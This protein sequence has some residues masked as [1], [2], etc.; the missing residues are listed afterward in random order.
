[1]ERPLCPAG[2][3][4]HEERG[5]AVV[6]IHGGART[7][8]KAQLTEHE[9]LKAAGTICP[10]VFQRDGERIRYVPQA[11]RTACKAAG[12]PGRLIHDMRRSA[13]RTFER[14]GVPRSVAMSIVGHKTESIYRR[15]AIV[16]EQCNGKLLLG[17]TPAWYADVASEEA[18]SRPL[19]RKRA[20]ATKSRS[21]RSG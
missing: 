8:L 10:F 19:G 1:M 11:W 3:T 15:Y 6:P 9:Q 16:D 14:A 2:R 20:K 13:V 5:G 12:C 4:Y 18:P 21:Q 17:S 7:I